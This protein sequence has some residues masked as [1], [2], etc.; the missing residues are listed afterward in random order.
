MWS[1][2]Y[3]LT[4][5]SRIVQNPERTLGSL[6]IELDPRYYKLLN[7]MKAHFVHGVPSLVDCEKL[8]VTGD[9]LFGSNVVIKGTAHISTRDESQHTVPDGSLIEGTVLLG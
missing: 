1:D 3:I 2:A 4:E 5:D 7:E 8:V 6:V 9:V